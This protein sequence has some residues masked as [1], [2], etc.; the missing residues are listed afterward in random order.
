MN[1]GEDVSL[2][3]HGAVMV[4]WPKYVPY[5][6]LD[7]VFYTVQRGHLA[8]PRCQWNSV[9][10]KNSSARRVTPHCA[11]PR[12]SFT[13]GPSRSVFFYTGNKLLN[14]HYWIADPKQTRYC[15]C[16]IMFTPCVTNVNNLVLVLKTKN[17]EN[18]VTQE[19]SALYQ[20]WGHIH[21]FLSTVK[22]QSHTL[23]NNFF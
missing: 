7:G 8:W 4:A 5:T 11:L 10:L 1:T 14:I 16:A 18:A 9:A 21:T 20:N 17:V 12:G 2:V 13:R 15:V 6:C 19:L 22:T 23:L 3:A